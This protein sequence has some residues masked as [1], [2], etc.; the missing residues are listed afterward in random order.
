VAPH[1]GGLARLVVYWKI[2]RPPAEHGSPISKQRVLM[3]KASKVNVLH[4][5]VRPQQPS[6]GVLTFLVLLDLHSNGWQGQHVPGHSKAARHPVAQ[7]KA[8]AHRVA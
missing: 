2:R 4:G 1:L 7:H 5:S 3:L 6:P 8:S